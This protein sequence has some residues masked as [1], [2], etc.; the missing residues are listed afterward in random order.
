M[1]IDKEIFAS[2]V[3]T[4]VGFVVGFVVSN[5]NKNSNPKQSAKDLNESHL[6]AKREYKQ[7]FIFRLVKE[8]GKTVA[9]AEVLWNELDE[10]GYVDVPEWYYE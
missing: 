4:V 7:N 10:K 9:E 5:A 1:K 6:K 2:A 3:S 8:Q